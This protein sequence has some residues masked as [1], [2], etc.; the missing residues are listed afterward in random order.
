MVC[1]ICAI[2]IDNVIN[3]NNDLLRLRLLWSMG[4]LSIQTKVSREG[5]NGGNGKSGWRVARIESWDRLVYPQLL[6]WCYDQIHNQEQDRRMKSCNL[7]TRL[8]LRCPPCRVAENREP[9]NEVGTIL[10]TLLMWWTNWSQF[11]C[12]CPDID[13]QFRHNTVKVAVDPRSDSRVTP[14]TT[15]TILRWKSLSLTG[16]THGNMTSICF[17]SITNC[18]LSK[19][20]C[21]SHKLEIHVSV[22]I[23]R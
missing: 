18:L 12:V 9:G 19:I 4:A 16:Q 8:A 10:I 11:S 13:D 23:L 6:S 5:Q 3:L 14:Q 1:R 7:V 2:G 17:L 20:V 21:S 22:R 15:L